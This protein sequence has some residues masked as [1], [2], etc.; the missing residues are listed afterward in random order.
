MPWKES[1]A[2]EQRNEFITEWS[3][4]GHS[5]TELS[6]I[7]EIS[8]KTAYKWL[9]RFELNG[10]GGLADGSR[11]PHHSP[12]AISEEKRVAIVAE[13]QS[14]PTWGSR[15]IVQ[16]LMRQQPKRKWPA[17]SSIG[18]LLKREGLIQGRRLRRRGFPA[19]H[20]RPARS[21]PG[22]ASLEAS[23][24]PESAA[25]PPKPV[26]GAPTHRSLRWVR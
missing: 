13:R 2:L 9:E 20:P 21:H 17:P 26:A 19:A 25:A 10:R 5:I 8:R 1:R 11:A 24:P 22:R 18:D 3:K 23:P 4:G 6:Q 7:F 16:S 12:Q 14:H 15:K